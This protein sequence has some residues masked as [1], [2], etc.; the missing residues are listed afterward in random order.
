MSLDTILDTILTSLYNFFVYK[1]PI[2]FAPYLLRIILYFHNLFTYINEI[3]HNIINGV[4]DSLSKKYL[5]FFKLSDVDYITYTINNN[6]TFTEEPEWVYDFETKVFSV[7]EFGHHTSVSH[8]PYIGASLNYI[9]EN[10]SKCVG[11]LSEWIVEQKVNSMDSKIP[12]QILAAAWK[13]SFDKTIVISYKNI[14]LSVITEDGDEITYSLE[15]NKEVVLSVDTDAEEDI[16]DSDS[17]IT[18]HSTDNEHE[19]EDKIEI[20]EPVLKKND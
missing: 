7:F 9:Y 1:I 13:Y 5:C 19:Q 15:T 4:R 2:F 10:K 17:Q 16:Q 14:Y 12:F 20:P 11:D 18:G 6:S 8:L 3:I